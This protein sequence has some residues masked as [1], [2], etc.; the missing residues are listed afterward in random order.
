[1]K[2]RFLSRQGMTL[3]EVLI[4]LVIITIGIS[5]LMVAMTQC[6]SVVRTARNREVALAIVEYVETARE[7]SDTGEER[8]IG[9]DDVVFDKEAARGAETQIEAPKEGAAPLTAEQ[10]IQSID[11]DMGDFLRSRFLLDNAGDG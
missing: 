3:I 1:M 9:A 4:A 10:W 8:G 5:S 6:L 7:Q 11:T 2:N